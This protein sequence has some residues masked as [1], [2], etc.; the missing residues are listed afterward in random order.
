MFKKASQHLKGMATGFIDNAI[1]GGINK[2]TS[3]F[4]G[5][6]KGNQ[7]KVAAE[8]LKKSPL[9]I[10]DSPSEKIS[11]DPLQFSY[12]QY[13]VDLNSSEQGHYILFRAISNEY[14]NDL[15]DLAIANKLGNNVTKTALGD[16]DEGTP[17]V[18]NF[19]SLLSKKG[20]T[21]KPLKVQ[22]SVQST[23]PTHSR[24]TAAIALYMPP[25][26]T[27]DYKMSYDIA[28]T[29]ASGTVARALGRAKSA[30]NTAGMI[31]EFAE[32]VKGTLVGVGKTMLDDIGQGLGAGEPARL[33]GKAFGV[34][35]NPHEEQFFE[36]PDFRSFS[37]DF[38]FWPR[39]EKE[40]NEVEKIIFLFKYHMHPSVDTKT[41]GGRLFKVPSEFEID[42]CHLGDNN[43]HLNRI[44]RCVLKDM[45]VSYGPEEQFS[46]FT[47]DNRG[48]M[49]VTHKLSLTFQETTFITKEHIYEGY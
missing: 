36:K 16:F 21:V 43:T 32:G 9:E 29:D 10:S 26:V 30:D 6:I 48:A 15:G 31:R 41:S 13:P 44:S 4:P 14:N 8:L 22:N 11:R 19:R 17:D 5:K 23:F 39:N 35:I 47:P 27:V 7:A 24:T 20:Q 46:T 38:E 40:A 49:P 33:V 1:T 2:F 3:G 18:V 25:G 45:S 37:Y 28:S 12:L 34:A 42:Y